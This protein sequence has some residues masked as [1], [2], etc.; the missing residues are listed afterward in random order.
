MGQYDVSTPIQI[1][2]LC[3]EQAQRHT[4]QHI[5]NIAYRDTDIIHTDTLLPYHKY[6][7]VCVWA[8]TP[9]EE[10][11]SLICLYVGQ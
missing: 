6:H 2:D 11:A 4:N 7:S 5:T 8:G 9:F 3:G 1:A 10:A